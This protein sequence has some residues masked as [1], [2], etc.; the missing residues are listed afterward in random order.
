MEHLHEPPAIT[1]PELDGDVSRRNPA[2]E[3]Q[4]RPPRVRS[5]G[6]R[7]ALANRP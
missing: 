2:L 6:A 3:E 5:A 4:R 1:V 7:T